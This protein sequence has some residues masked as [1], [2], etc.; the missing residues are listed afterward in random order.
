MFRAQTASDET[1]RVVGQRKGGF[2]RWRSSSLEILTF[3]AARVPRLCSSGA[4]FGGV[5]ALRARGLKPRLS[6]PGP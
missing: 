2:A 4:H 1:W 5:G 3:P 6:S